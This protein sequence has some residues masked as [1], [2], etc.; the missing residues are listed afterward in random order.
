M[1][2]CWLGTSVA[3][4]DQ[5]SPCACCSGEGKI[6]ALMRD[7]STK[8]ARIEEIG[9]ALL[10]NTL[11]A[12]ASTDLRKRPD[13]ESGERHGGQVVAPRPSPLT[14]PCMRTQHA[15]A[16]WPTCSQRRMRS[17]LCCL[18][19]AW[20]YS[21]TAASC[22]SWP[23]AL[24]SW[25]ARRRLVRACVR[26]VW[27]ARALLGEVAAREACPNQPTVNARS[28]FP[29]R[30]RR[31]QRGRRAAGAAA[32]ERALGRRACVRAALVRTAAVPRPPGGAPQVGLGGAV[33]AVRL[34]GA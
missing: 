8:Q 3:A 28:P 23:R 27:L 31:G 22:W 14:R 26:G 2:K 4:A 18:A 15:P 34:C 30:C 33:L 9:Q 21:P 11:L 1:A 10:K 16:L 20:R 7:G 29:L 24:R 25:M 13:A 17:T 5:H 19:T 32:L 6:L 12:A